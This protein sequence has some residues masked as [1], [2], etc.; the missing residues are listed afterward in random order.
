MGCQILLYWGPNTATAGCYAKIDENNSY[1][2]HFDP[3]TN[4]MR[5]RWGYK[6][7][8]KPSDQSEQPDWHKIDERRS[9]VVISEGGALKLP[10]RL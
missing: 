8:N 2:V 5:L 9:S 6:T 1:V 10:G 3:T 4:E 7:E